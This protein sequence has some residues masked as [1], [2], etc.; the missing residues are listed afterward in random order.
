MTLAP[1][2]LIVDVAVDPTIEDAWNEWYDTV[3]LP[4]IADCPGFAEAARYVSEGADGRHYVAVYDISGPEALDTA[5]FASRRGWA[6]FA[7]HV[8]ADVRVYRRFTSIGAP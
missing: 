2:L 8:T 3:H 7:D 1:W 4:E 5:E 6:E